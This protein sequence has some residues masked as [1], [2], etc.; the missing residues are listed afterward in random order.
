[1]QKESPW[2]SSYNHLDINPIRTHCYRD[3]CIQLCVKVGKR[4][5]TRQ[6]FS[7]KPGSTLIRPACTRHKA[8]C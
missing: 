5:T 2:L 7:G 1:M 6:E 4:L 3:R 8:A